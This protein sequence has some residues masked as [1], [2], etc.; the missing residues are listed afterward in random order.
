MA[1]VPLFLGVGCGVT[2]LFSFLKYSECR[3]EWA[4]FHTK[5]RYEKLP[6]TEVKAYLNERINS[7]SRLHKGSHVNLGGV[8]FGTPDTVHTQTQ[9]SYEVTLTGTHGELTSTWMYD[10][11]TFWDSQPKCITFPTKAAAELFIE[12]VT[13]K[14][15]LV[16]FLRHKL[17]ATKHRLYLAS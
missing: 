7:T 8:Q 3:D 13:E 6:C 11:S 16:T 10:P 2:S 12:R 9:T 5:D 1:F 4:A 14:P 17:D 15:E